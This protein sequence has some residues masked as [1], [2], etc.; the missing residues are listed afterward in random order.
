MDLLV[1]KLLQLVTLVVVAVAFAGAL[2]HVLELPGKRRLSKEAYFTVQSIYYPGF[3][4]AGASEPLAII[5]TLVLLVT[6]PQGATFWLVFVALAGFV[7]MQLVYW[8]ITHSLNKVWLH[9]TKLSG[10]ASGFFSFAATTADGKQA[11]TENW[12]RLRDRW[13]YSHVLRAGLGG[14]SFIALAISVCAG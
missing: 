2:A 1:F 7:G 3:T 10:A 6:T 8:L 13:E 4:I 9:G 14:F 12:T 5:L 11:A